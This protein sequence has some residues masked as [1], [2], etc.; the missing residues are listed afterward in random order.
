MYAHTSKNSNL[1]QR[2]LRDTFVGKKLV[3]NNTE[4]RNRVGAATML[5][6]HRFR[7]TNISKA[8]NLQPTQSVVQELVKENKRLWRENKRVKAEKDEAIRQMEVKLFVLEEE[9]EEKDKE[10][11]L[12]EHKIYIESRLV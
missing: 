2:D 1:V 7:G 3:Q 6:Q 5:R 10:I 4:A 12:L 8:R 11:N 9:R